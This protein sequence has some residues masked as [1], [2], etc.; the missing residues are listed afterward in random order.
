ME[1]LRVAEAADYIGISKSTLD[2]LRC[3]GG[4][5]IFIKVGARVVYDRM[6]LDAWLA[7][8]KVANTAGSKVGGGI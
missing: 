1:A 6:D 7:G 3:Y 5:P 8:K 4:G 2:K